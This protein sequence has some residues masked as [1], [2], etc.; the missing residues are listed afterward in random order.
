MVAKSKSRSHVRKAGRS[1][2]ARKQCFG[3]CARQSHHLDLGEHAAERADAVIE[4]LAQLLV[5][6]GQHEC[7]APDS[8]R[9]NGGE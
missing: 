3:L 8:R 7:E 4:R 2:F 9:E 6:V 1:T 5:T